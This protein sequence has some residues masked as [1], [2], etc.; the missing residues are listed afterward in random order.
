LTPEGVRFRVWAPQ[1]EGLLVRVDGREVALARGDDGVH[2][3]FVPGLSQDARYAFVFPDGRVRPDPAS[4]RQPAGVHGESQ[5]FEPGAFA[6]RHAD[7]RGR[8]LEELAFY[9]LHVGTFTREGTLDAAAERLGE[10]AALGITCVELMPVQP[11]PGARGWGYDGVSLHAVHEDYG[12]P[13]ALQRFVDAAHGVGL[14]VCMDVVLN[15]LGPEGNYLADFGPYF[16]SKHLTPWGSGINFDG[17]GSAPVRRFMVEATLQWVEDFRVD[18]LRLDAVSAI[19]DEGATHLVAE[20]VQAVAGVAR[21]SGRHLHVVAES[22]VNARNVVEAAPAGWGCA[23]AW[24]DDFHHALHAVLTGETQGY[25][26][27]F[28]GVGP[29]VTALAEG[30]VFQGQ[31]SRYRGKDLGT[32]PKGLVPSQ[33]VTFAQNHDQ[34]GNRAQGERL[35][36]LVPKEALEPIAA[37]TVLGPGLPLLFMGEEYGEERP[38]L[39]FTSHSDAGL[40]KAVREGRDTHLKGFPGWPPPDPQAVETFERSKLQ[41]R[42]DDRAFRLREVYRRLL[43]LRRQH[44]KVISREWPRVVA[45]GKLIRLI[46]TGLTV[47]VN[48]SAE[49]EGGFPPWGWWVRS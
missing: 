26:Q 24:T 27:D 35:S 2:S 40:A 20:V 31:R 47:E 48:L 23:A 11:F 7:Y 29:L 44:L 38:F 13:R 1:V 18:V 6:W 16:S 49:P 4:R 3:A 15:H 42:E 19:L 10:L 41:L 14:A 25:Y 30:Y 22:D 12:G 36:T 17:E 34:V 43:E 45:T 39:Y 8:P 28:G 37:L 32:S 46:R 9:E 5:L 21:A 33:F